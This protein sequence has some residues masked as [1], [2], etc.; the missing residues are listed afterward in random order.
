MKELYEKL[1]VYNRDMK[2]TGLIALQAER[3]FYSYRYLQIS[4]RAVRSAAFMN[5]HAEQ[6]FTHSRGLVAQ[7]CL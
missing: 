4:Y 3:L 5:F 7:R 1:Q 6:G 2:G